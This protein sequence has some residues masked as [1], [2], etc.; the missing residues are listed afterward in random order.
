MNCSL[1]GSYIHGISQASILEWVAISSSSESSWPRLSNPH[2]LH[3]L[4]WQMDSLPLCH[5]SLYTK[6]L[7]FI[8]FKV[9]FHCLYPNAYSPYTLPLGT[10][11]LI[12]IS[13]SL[14][15][16]FWSIND[17]QLLLVPI[18]KH[19]DFF[20]IH[21]KMITINLCTVS[22]HIKIISSFWNSLEKLRYLI[23]VQISL[24]RKYIWK[25]LQKNSVFNNKKD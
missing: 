16:S 22:H 11:N 1:P 10:T 15:V 6:S 2:L 9:L 18:I 8:F 13:M 20:S 19:S 5:L 25:Y 24:I 12:T 7:V 17:L 4:H 3:L 21:F 14:F 23:I